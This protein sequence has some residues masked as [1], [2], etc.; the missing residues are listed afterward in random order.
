MESVAD[1]QEP[2]GSPTRSDV[3]F[4]DGT[5]VLQANATLFRVYRGV[6]AAQSPIFRDAFSIPQPATQE[7]YEGCPLVVLHDSAEDLRLFLLATHDAGYLVNTPVDGMTTLSALL[8]LST[9]Y[10][11]G[12]IRSRMIFILQTL[13]PSSLDDYLQKEP[14]AAWEE[15]DYDDF[16]AL[17]LAQEVE[18]PS[19]LPTIYYE[20]CG[21]ETSYLMNADI[22][23]ADKTKCI[24]AKETF[25]SK[26]SGRVYSFLF[27]HP[28][29]ASCTSVLQCAG[30][31]LR[32]LKTTPLQLYQVFPFGCGSY[33]QGL[34][35]DCVEDANLRFQR[36]LPAFWDALPS[37]FGL[38]P[39]TDLL[40]DGVE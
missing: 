13:Y 10:E 12:H 15:V 20:C 11:V 38:A 29:S 36:E 25:S 6:L 21:Y 28:P 5:V 31:R 35:S 18:I 32:R 23:F 7:T 30:V 1:A 19:I 33:L 8:R 26:W 34:C 37:L 4:A 39:W 14:P 27:I 3:W 16:V 40:S 24:L 2:T 9:K 17:R 22:S